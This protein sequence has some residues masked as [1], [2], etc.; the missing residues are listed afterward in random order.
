MNMR[1]AIIPE[2]IQFISKSL[3]APVIKEIKIIADN[4]NNAI[5][6]YILDRKC[7]FKH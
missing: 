3:K 5:S 1:I 2:S 7:C 4:K 6:N